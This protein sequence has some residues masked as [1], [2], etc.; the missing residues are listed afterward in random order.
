MPPSSTPQQHLGRASTRAGTVRQHRERLPARPQ[1]EP[2]RYSRS[3]GPAPTVL[4][5]I[6]ADK[7]HRADTDKG[8]R[9]DFQRRVHGAVERVGVPGPAPPRAEYWNRNRVLSDRPATSPATMTPVSR[10]HDLQ[11]EVTAGTSLRADDEW[12]RPLPPQ[13]GPRG[14]WGVDDWYA[15]NRAAQPTPAAS[16]RQGQRLR[17]RTARQRARPHLSGCITLRRREENARS[18]EG[19]TDGNNWL[20]H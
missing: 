6:A 5:N 20:R 12:C 1:A 4:Q 8:G 16:E 17:K 3:E 15:F 11:G 2:D 9:V 10:R 13:V 7:P 14:T 18:A 19:A